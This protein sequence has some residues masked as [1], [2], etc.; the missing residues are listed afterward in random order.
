[1]T[2]SLSIDIYQYLKNKQ[3]MIPVTKKAQEKN[4]RGGEKLIRVES[5]DKRKT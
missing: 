2:F 4:Q 5:I 3:K 1:M